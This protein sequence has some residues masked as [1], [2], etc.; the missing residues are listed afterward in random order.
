[1]VLVSIT[2][3]YRTSASVNAYRDCNI[4]LAAGAG[5]GHNLDSQQAGVLA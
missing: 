2:R 5:F 3:A 4:G 1:M